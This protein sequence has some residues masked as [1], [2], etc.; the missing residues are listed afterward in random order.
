M[1]SEEVWKDIK[2]FEQF[3]QIS[4]KG[5]I[6]SKDYYKPNGHGEYLLKGRILKTH[7]NNRGYEFI[8]MNYKGKIKQAY[9]HRLVAEAFIDN[10]NNYKA[11]NHIDK[12]KENNCVDNLEWC[13]YSYNSR[14]S[15]SKK[16]KGT[17]LKTNE[18]VFYNA[19][20]DSVKDGF[21]VSQIVACCKGK[22]KS[23]KGYKWEYC[24]DE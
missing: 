20:I 17:N 22:R 9:I 6:R 1:I 23:H 12:N 8:R 5:R 10:P 16:V 11:V 14:Y 2:G 3:Y 19:I 18:I 7:K 24:E 4:N 21:V 15:N 13:T